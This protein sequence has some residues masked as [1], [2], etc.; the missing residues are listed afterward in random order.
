MLSAP[1]YGVTDTIYPVIFGLMLVGVAQA[2]STLPSIPQLIEILTP[3]INDPTLKSGVSDM[4][5]ALFIMSMG[6]GSLIGPL[7]GGSVYDHYGGNAD[8]TLYPE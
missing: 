8:R 2:F 4:A 6:F 7:L 5:A 3:V 1:F